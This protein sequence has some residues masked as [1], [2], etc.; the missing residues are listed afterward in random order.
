MTCQQCCTLC[1]SENGNALNSYSGDTQ[2]ESRWSKY[3]RVFLRLSADHPFMWSSITTVLI[4]A[5]LADLKGNQNSTWKRN[6]ILVAHSK[7]SNDHSTNIF[8]V[9]FRVVGGRWHQPAV[10][11][12]DYVTPAVWTRITIIN[13]SLSIPCYLLQFCIWLDGLKFQR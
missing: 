13:S 6:V 8:P 1:R 12:I 10:F 9:P 2:F 7:A 5:S 4:T 3:F 11:G